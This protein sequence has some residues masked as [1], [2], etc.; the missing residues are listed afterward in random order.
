[1]KK[2]PSSLARLHPSQAALLEVGILF[3]PAIPA[4]LWV[5]PNVSGDAQWA[6]QTLSYLYVLAGAVWIGRRRW[7]WSQLGLNWSGLW[8][9][10]AC[11][12]AIIA[13]RT[14][15]ILGV[16]WNMATLRLSPL[17]LAAQVLFYLF[18]VGLGEELLF[19]GLVY[20]ALQDWRGV[21][22]A[23]WGSSIGF[24]LWHIFGQGPL[25]GAATLF[26]GLIFALM[27]WRAGGIT[28][29][30][31]VHGLMDILA[32]LMLPGVDVLSLGRPKVPY[33]ALLWAGLLL[34]IL[35]PLYLW[36]LYPRVAR[37]A[38]QP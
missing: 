20:R 4:Y 25:I 17:E 34:L 22:A 28:G 14:L 3:L 16:S 13:G 27:R 15:V 29:L 35:T 26:Y 31:L 9:S 1:M 19:R 38:S 37:A 8:L 32:L 23:I 12:L 30:I 33:P 7:T 24:M 36:L 11:G 18:L 2:L 6:F 21:R 10:L 5:W